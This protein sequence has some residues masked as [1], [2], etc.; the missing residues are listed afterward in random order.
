MYHF[1]IVA[2]LGLACWKFVG[3]LLGLMKQEMDGSVRAFVTLGTGVLFAEILGYS[4][5][6][7]WGATFRSD[8]MGPVF[9][10]LTIGAL[11]YV[12]HHMLGV[13]EAYGRRSRDQAREI[14]QRIPRAA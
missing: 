3:M 1:A 9:T 11:A 8:W 2:M 13:L 5:F 14:E 7:G 10:G 12:W 6:A 4:V